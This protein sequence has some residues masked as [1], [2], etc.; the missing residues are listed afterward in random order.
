[1]STPLFQ[2]R[3]DGRLMPGLRKLGQSEAF[4]VDQS[5]EWRKKSGG[6]FVEHLRVQ[7]IW[8]RDTRDFQN[9]QLLLD[10]SIQQG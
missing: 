8:T 3:N 7:S 4:V 1:M 2:Y 9:M 5:Q 10:I 6:K